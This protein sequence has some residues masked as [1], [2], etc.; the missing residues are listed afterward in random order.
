MHPPCNATGGESEGK[1]ERDVN[2]IG[3]S[4]HGMGHDGVCVCCGISSKISTGL[5]CV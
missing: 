1:P 3:K 4:F 5:E 2:N